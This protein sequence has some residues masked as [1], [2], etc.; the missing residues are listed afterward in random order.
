MQIL[1]NIPATLATQAS[2]TLLVTGFGNEYA[3]E[4]DLSN[5]LVQTRPD[6]PPNTTFGV[7]LR[8]GGKNPQN[9][10]LAGR[11]ANLDVQY[12]VGIASG[13]PTQFL[14]EGDD[15]V[16]G[17]TDIATYVMSLSAP[18][19]V[20]STSYGFDERDLSSSILR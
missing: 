2:N 14:A 10:A 1:Y 3:Q 19:S 6:L 11:E 20:V 9:P 16:A 17:F 4:A 8:T 15:G 5:F 12:S 18:P 13:V 7:V